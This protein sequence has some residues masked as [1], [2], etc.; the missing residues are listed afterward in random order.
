M[1]I[2]KWQTIGL[3]QTK[4]WIGA[5]IGAA[6]SILGGMIGKSSAKDTNA[7]NYQIAKENRD[8]Q[9]EMSNTAYQRAAADMKAAGINPLMAAMKGGASTPSPSTP[10]MQD[11]GAA[12]ISAGAKSFEK[13]AQAANMEADLDNKRQQNELLKEQTNLTR[14]NA[15]KVQVDT[16]LAEASKGTKENFWRVAEDATSVIPNAY[17]S[18]KDFV[19]G[20]TRPVHSAASLNSEVRDRETKKQGLPPYPRLTQRDYKERVAAWNFIK[21]GNEPQ[22]PSEGDSN[23]ETHRKIFKYYQEMKR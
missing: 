2:M 11:T 16:D 17:K 7:Q 1:N 3:P 14:E 5:A 6:G 9:E 12:A 21:N 4:E 10:T 15:R 18:V 19:S 8:W 20:K 13:I 23:Y 22:W